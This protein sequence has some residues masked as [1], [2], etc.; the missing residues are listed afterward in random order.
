MDSYHSKIVYRD[1]ELFSTEVSE[2]SSSVL[3]YLKQLLS[4][5][6]KLGHAV[7]ME[8]TG[9]GRS[10]LKNNQMLQKLYIEAIEHQLKTVDNYG[11]VN[12]ASSDENV[13]ALCRQ[14]HSCVYCLL[15][16]MNPCSDM[17]DLSPI[18]DQ[19]FQDLLKRTRLKNHKQLDI[20][21]LYNCLI[22][23]KTTYL[24]TKFFDVENSL[25]LGKGIGSCVGEQFYLKQ[26]SAGALLP[27]VQITCHQS[28]IDDRQEAW[29]LLYFHGMNGNHVLENV[30]VCILQDMTIQFVI[31]III[32]I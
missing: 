27:P 19:L 29:K 6:A 17:T 11:G 18:L 1:P 15:A 23:R 3:N 2:I 5:D 10:Y 9:E 8:L 14:S 21:K 12:T 32:S 26:S 4:E 22:G 7:I 24:I 20:S 28:L 25:R 30:V 31:A 16:V 13:E